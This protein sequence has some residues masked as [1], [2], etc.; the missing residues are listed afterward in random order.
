MGRP[1]L[2]CFVAGDKLRVCGAELAAG[3]PAEAL[4]A[5]HTA[6]LQL[7]FNGT[8]R[9]GHMPLPSLSAASLACAN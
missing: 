2:L 1:E 8:H 5:A 3:A 9:C 6:L 7:R 4:V